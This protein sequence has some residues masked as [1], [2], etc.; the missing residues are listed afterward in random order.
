M[1]A[2]SIW[3]LLIPAME[4]AEG[5]GRVAVIP[6]VLEFWLGIL[7]L[8]MLDR[9]IPHLHQNS[10]QPEGRSTCKIRANNHDA[11]SGDTS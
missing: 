3:S 6:V 5:L 7:F 10:E 2:A 8:L 9:L 11:F 1:V 4:Q